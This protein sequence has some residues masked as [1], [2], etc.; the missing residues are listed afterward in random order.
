MLDHE[1]Q[2][3]YVAGPCIEHWPHVAEVVALFLEQTSGKHLAIADEELTPGI[4]VEVD[5]VPDLTALA[6]RVG[7][8]IQRL[9]VKYFAPDMG[10]ATIKLCRRAMRVDANLIVHLDEAGV[11]RADVAAFQRALELRTAG[12]GRGVL[13]GD[14]RRAR[15]RLQP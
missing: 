14:R 15:P 6:E 8:A 9:V 7:P 5:T 10:A 13:V 2:V 11:S 1:R 4:I 12:Y 3:A